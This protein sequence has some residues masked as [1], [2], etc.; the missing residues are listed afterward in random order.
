MP[1]PNLSTPFFYG[2]KLRLAVFCVTNA[3]TLKCLHCSSDAGAP[4]R[5]ELTL[6]EI[7]LMIDDLYNAGM[8]H[9]GISGGEP[10]LRKDL[11]E[12]VEY[13]I[14]KG[15][16]VG[17]S[18][19][20]TLITPFI[21]DKLKG[22]NKGNGFL[23]IQVSLDGASE[24]VNDKIRGPGTFKKATHAF[25]VLKSRGFR[26]TLGFT[27]NRL[28]FSEVD[29]IIELGINLGANEISFSF[30]VPTGRGGKYLDLRPD[31]W[32]KILL[33]LDEKKKEMEGIV[34]I[35][36][37][38]PRY[39]WI[40]KENLLESGCTAGFSH[41]G[42]TADGWVYP[43]IMLPIP[44]FNIRNRSKTLQEHWKDNLFLKKIRER[45]NLKGKC[46]TCPNVSYCGGCRAVAYCYTN[47]PFGDDP[48]CWVRKA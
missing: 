14:S 13:A 10:F 11:F 5:S 27:P 24:A 45:T 6:E 26:M 42:I 21:A 15:L 31:E 36:F 20:G 44:L 41:C 7:K 46:S 23:R 32:A 39:W 9:F 16:D 38:E 19:N 1:R 4:L 40:T 35:G 22:L 47:D 12:I 25:E 3:C 34:K 43:C 33:F 28:N 8:M 17:I 29:Q 2:K 37:H 18:T 48:R 30:Y